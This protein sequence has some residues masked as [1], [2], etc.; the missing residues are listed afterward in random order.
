MEQNSGAQTSSSPSHIL[1]LTST[2]SQRFNQINEAI[3]N[4]PTYEGF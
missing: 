3:I 1:D 4:R 2:F